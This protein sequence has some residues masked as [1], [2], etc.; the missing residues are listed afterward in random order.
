MSW[1]DPQG[2]PEALEGPL[3]RIQGV[4]DRIEICA[5]ALS[6]KPASAAL[7][8]SIADML[9]ALHDELDVAGEEIATEV[10]K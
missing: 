4:I 7:K 1:R 3:Q 9:M 10:R 8:V 2:I 5:A 6:A